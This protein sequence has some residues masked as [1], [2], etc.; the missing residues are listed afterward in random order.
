MSWCMKTITAA[1]PRTPSRNEVGPIWRLGLVLVILFC[2]KDG[3]K[4]SRAVKMY[5]AIPESG[6]DRFCIVA[7]AYILSLK[8]RALVWIHMPLY[9]C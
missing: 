4:N 7:S 3:N 5:D 8:P 6:R 9:C 1:I 2:T